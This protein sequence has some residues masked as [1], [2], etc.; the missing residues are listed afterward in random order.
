MGLNAE[1]GWR[2]KIQNFEKIF[3]Y[4]YTETYNREPVIK[5]LMRRCLGFGRLTLLRYLDDHAE[6]AS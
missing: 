6:V 5:K 1:F 2:K 3:K 4:F